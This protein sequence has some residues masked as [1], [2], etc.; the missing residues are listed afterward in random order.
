[1]SLQRV[2]WVGRKKLKKGRRKVLETVRPNWYGV[3][4]AM[5]TIEF[6]GGSEP[7]LT[8]KSKTTGNRSLRSL[9]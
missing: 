2:K 1:M 3:G 5:Q 9:D 7:L 6:S 8:S 4:V